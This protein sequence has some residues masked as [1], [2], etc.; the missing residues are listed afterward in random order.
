LDVPEI[1]NEVPSEEELRTYVNQWLGES[2]ISMLGD[3]DRPNLYHETIR[4]AISYLSSCNCSCLIR[5]L[6]DAVFDGLKRLNR[7]PRSDA[8]W[9]NSN[10][11]PT[12]PKLGC[13]CAAILVRQPDDELALLGKAALN[14]AHAGDFDV[15]SWQRLLHLG[16]LS[17]DD[18]V[19][20]GMFL[21]A[22]G[23]PN[24]E[25]FALLLRETR[26]ETEALPILNEV[27]QNAGA[28]LAEWGRTVQ[29]LIADAEPSRKPPLA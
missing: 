26:T 24:A 6:K 8:F 20:A 4:E 27:V 11:R 21:E 1:K 10:L 19:C 22:A 5:R 3:I 18:L 15:K 13:Y 2:C 25:Q 12:A 7:L 23:S 14:L 16:T 9:N 28:F 17:L 29:R